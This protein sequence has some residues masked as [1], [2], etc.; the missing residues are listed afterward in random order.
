MDAGIKGEVSE[1]AAA[2]RSALFEAHERA[3]ASVRVED[4]WLVPAAFGDA[5]A[6]YEAVRGGESAGLFDLSSRARVEVSGAEAVQFLNGMVTNDVAALADGAWIHAAFPNVQ[7]RLLARVRVLRRAGA[8]LFDTEPATHAALL[9]TLE[10]FTL[11]GDFRVKDLTLETAL[12][13]VQ[14]ARAEEIVGAALGFDAA[15]LDRGRVASVSDE[16][17]GD[18]PLSVIRATHTAED[19][20]DVFVS[21]RAAASVWDAL[22]GAGARRAGCDAL[23]VLRVEAGVPRYGVDA[24]EANVVLEVVDE[25]EAVSYT[26]GCYVGQEIIARIHWRGHVA[27]KLA[28]LVFDEGA[29]PV[30]GAKIKGAEGEREIG[31]VTSVVNSPRLGAPVALGLVRY[32]HLAAGT[33]VKVSDGEEASVTARVAELPLVRG[34]W[35]AGDVEDASAGKE[36]SA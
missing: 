31:R 18:E 33:E 32:E 14:G 6:E 13:S 29:A 9:K 16:R 3:G 15:G 4:G 24:S 34:G 30:A 17:F 25:A 22:A 28:G 10:R 23:E 12:V 5:G 35:Y 26:K 11:A 1:A 36:S 2:R 7:G 27:K 20:F 21:A 19:G 8:F